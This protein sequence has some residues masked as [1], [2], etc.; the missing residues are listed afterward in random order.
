MDLLP[1]NPPEGTLNPHFTEAPLG[2]GGKA[3]FLSTGGERFLISGFGFN[4]FLSKINIQKS[5]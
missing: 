5:E 3:Q 4:R 2:I 1:L